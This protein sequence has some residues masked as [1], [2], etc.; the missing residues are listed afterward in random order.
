MFVIHASGLGREERCTNPLYTDSEGEPELASLGSV[1]HVFKLP[2]SQWISFMGNPNAGKTRGVGRELHSFQTF[3]PFLSFWAFTPSS[4]LLI[5]IP[6]LTS[7]GMSRQVSLIRYLRMTLTVILNDKPQVLSKWMVKHLTKPK[8]LS[9]TLPLLASSARL[10][11]PRLQTRNFVLQLARGIK[12][13]A[14][15]LSS[16]LKP[17]SVLEIPSCS[18]PAE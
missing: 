12:T 1:I 2:L 17:L 11:I 13:S 4:S 8:K 9:I 6:C 3:L 14:N 16:M 15:I 7:P 10:D 18:L 5:H